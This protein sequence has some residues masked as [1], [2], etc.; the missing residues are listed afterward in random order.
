[1]VAGV[2]RGFQ[3]AADR[4]A[5]DIRQR[6]LHLGVHDRLDPRALADEHGIMVVPITALAAEGAD[7]ASIHQLTVTDPGSFSAGTLFVGTTRLIIFNPAHSDGRQ[8]NSVAHELAHFFLEH[9]P[10]PAIGPGG[11]RVWVQEMEDEADLL[12]AILL[13]PRETALACARVGLPHAIGAA[14]FGVSAELMQWRTDHSGASH[15]ARAAARLSDRTIPRLPKPDTAALLNQCD[16]AWLGD[17]NETDW[18]SL[19]RS[20]GRALAKGSVDD[21]ARCLQQPLATR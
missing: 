15:Q 16:L 12:A 19:L 13:V 8:A 7:P 3:A 21:L 5:A 9:A 1:V 10:G 14:R 20:C 11:C 18:Q 4:L 6:D 2:R 17:L